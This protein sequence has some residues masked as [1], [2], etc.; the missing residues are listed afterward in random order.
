M[1]ILQM[2]L[3]GVLVGGGWSSWKDAVA[4]DENG[5]RNT[6][7]S[8]L[9]NY[10]KVPT[11]APPETLTYYLQQLSDDDLIGRAAIVVLL[12][13]QAIRTDEELLQMTDDDQRNALIVENSQRASLAEADLQKMSDQQ[14]VTT[15]FETWYPWGNPSSQP[16]FPPFPGTQA[17]AYKA[18]G[19][20][21]NLSPGVDVRSQYVNVHQDLETYYSTIEAHL[22]DNPSPNSG[23]SL[24]DWQAVCNQLLQ[25]IAWVLDVRLLFDGMKDFI[26]ESFLGKELVFQ[27]VQNW[28]KIPADEKSGQDL[29]LVKNLVNLMAA[30][31]SALVAL[32]VAVAAAP[33]LPVAAGLIYATAGAWSMSWSESNPGNEDLK[34]AFAQLSTTISDQFGQFLIAN[35]TVE[36]KVLSDYGDLMAMGTQLRSGDAGWTPNESSAEVVATQD[37][38]RLWLWKTLSPLVWATNNYAAVNQ[39]GYKCFCKYPDDWYIRRIETESYVGS[40][41]ANYPFN[42]CYWL[43]STSGDCL[44]P[45]QVQAALDAGAVIT[46]ILLGQNGWHLGFNRDVGF[47]VF[48][49]PGVT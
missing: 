49:P 9:N 44:D 1:L 28:L 20:L 12:R 19:A 13:D 3:P 46:D 17:D 4:L 21:Q 15:A 2:T 48:I 30:V 33:A 6:V 41:Y 43:S 18:V 35:T 40:E 38:Y 42:V 24:A 32:P 14:L 5:Q 26:D 8:V 23:Y 10:M 37:Y 7:I 16:D 34:V 27:E 29:L 25:E 11:T 45:K 22:N 36:T 31:G 47:T 39:T